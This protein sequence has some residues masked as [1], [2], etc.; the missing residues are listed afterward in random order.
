MKIKLLK[1]YIIPHQNINGATK[2]KYVNKKVTFK[3]H[4]RKQLKVLGKFKKFQ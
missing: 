1:Y 3:T 4:N 2:T